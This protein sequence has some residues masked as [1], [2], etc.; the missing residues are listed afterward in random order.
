[1]RHTAIALVAMALIA[2]AAQAHPQ[3]DVRASVAVK[4]ADLDLSEPE[5]VMRL[6]R[7]V[8]KAARL[9]CE[10]NVSQVYLQSQRTK[11]DSCYALTIANALAQVNQTVMLS[12]ESKRSGRSQAR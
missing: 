7:R 11:A 4:I 8:E 6:H 3:N 2:S 5:D 10:S 9:V 12:R 1:M